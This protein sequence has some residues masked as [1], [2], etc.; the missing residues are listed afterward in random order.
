VAHLRGFPSAEIARRRRR[1]PGRHLAVRP[2]V[3]SGATSTGS[4]TC[5]ADMHTL[6]QRV[7][8]QGSGKKRLHGAMCMRRLGAWRKRCDE[9]RPQEGRA[10]KS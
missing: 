10:E 7:A 4:T 6:V 1:D 9:E 2:S 5:H 3:V 8:R